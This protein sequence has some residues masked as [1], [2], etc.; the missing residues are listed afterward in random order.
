MFLFFSDNIQDSD[1]KDKTSSVK[2]AENEIQCASD[3]TDTG[4]FLWTASVCFKVQYTQSL[5]Q[6]ICKTEHISLSESYFCDILFT[7]YIL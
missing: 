7:S 4:V 6:D 2:A 5:F 3:M 1:T